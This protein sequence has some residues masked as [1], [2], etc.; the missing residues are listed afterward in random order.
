[1][2]THAFNTTEKI[3]SAADLVQRIAMWQFQLKKVVFTNGVFDILHPGHIEYLEKARALGDVLLVG[4]NSDASVARLKPG[5]PYQNQD[6]R[7]KLLAALQFVDCVTVFEEDTPARLIQQVKPAVLVK[8]ADYTVDTI[9]GAEF[10]LAGGG[11]VETIE[12]VAG[13]STTAIVE[14]IRA[15]R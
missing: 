3:L 1:M 11:T 10:V 14:K 8:G 15:G 6:A 9:V 5:R 7:A 4:L 13:E 12:L 2:G